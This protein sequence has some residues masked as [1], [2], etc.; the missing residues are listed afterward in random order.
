VFTGIVAEVGNLTALRPLQAGGARIAVRC[1]KVRSEL[2][3]GDS[4]CVSGVCTTVV[5]L[6]EDGFSADLSPETLRRSTL[7]SARSGVRVNVEPAVR[8]GQAIGGHHVAGHVDG[9]GR[10]TAWRR[11]GAGILAEWQAPTEA[12]PYLVDKGSVAVDGVSL[13]P[14]GVRDGRFRVSLI[15][16]TLRETTLGDLRGGDSV[17]VEADLLAKYARAGSGK[18]D[19]VTLDLLRRSGFLD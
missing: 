12:V 19:G 5:V 13:T 7:G 3:I 18:T 11:S 8:A 15:P 4:V 17:N 1:P 14:Y 16:E 9:I 6:T 2:G 10:V